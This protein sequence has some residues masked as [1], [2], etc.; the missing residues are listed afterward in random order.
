MQPMSLKRVSVYSSCDNIES[1]FHQKFGIRIGPGS[2]ESRGV[3]CG[4]H[5]F[6]ERKRIQLK[7]GGKTS[8]RMSFLAKQVKI[9]S[10]LTCSEKLH[11]M[12]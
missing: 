4:T 11:K 3:S 2:A 10:I 6:C 5:V 1:E 9:R 12:R 7:K 8:E